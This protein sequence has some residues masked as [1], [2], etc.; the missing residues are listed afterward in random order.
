MA[1]VV[2]DRVQ[3]TSSTTGTGT[4][5]LSGAVN[6]F[7]T[8]SSVL[9]NGD[10]TYYC[11]TDSVNNDFEVGLGTYSAGTLARTTI[12]ESTNA[13]SAVNFGAGVK[14]VFITYP[15]EKAVY[16]DASDNITVPG[17]VD[18]RDIASDG[19]KLDGIEAG[20]DVTDT[21][22]V[23]AAGALMD[24]E[25]TSLSGVKTLTVPDNT[26]ISTFGATLV[27]DADAATSRTTLGLG[28]ASTQDVGTSA[29]NVVQLD[30]SARLPA[31]DGSQL[32]GIVSIPSGVITMWSGTV[33]SIPSGW[34]ICDGLNGTPNLTGR[35]VI[36]ADADAAG[37]YNVG[38]TGGSSTVALSEAEMP[39]HTHTVS[40]NTSNTGA[41]THTGNT[42]NTGAH[43][44]TGNTSNSGNHTHTG[45][46]SNTGAHSHSGTTANVGNHTHNG[47][48]SNTGAHS[49]N[50]SVP[51]N[52]LYGVG[53]N[54]FGG[55]AS[56]TAFNV[57]ISTS[58]TGAHSHNFTTAGGGSHAHNFNTS[59][60]GAHS[61]SFTTA[62]GGD[63]SHSYTT[64]SSGAHSHTLTVDSGGAHSHT[65]SGTAAASGSGT[66]HENRPPYY[67]LAYI[68][69]T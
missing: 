55:S 23:T 58:N 34:V 16:L 44:H 18:G 59:N 28:T 52:Q 68:M 49:H 63:H 36:H 21:A 43:T 13:G 56:G 69:K 9:S 38:D 41:H 14:E 29:G 67:A 31:V 17:L 25:L 6:G 45:N 54:R 37:T 33:A 57:G 1:F 47:S 35:F 50:A 53:T 20:A 19:S 40:G 5:T 60:T 48:T 27:D 4:F 39:S 3:E 12:I 8:F 66:A 11:I 7:R 15:A 65:I 30:G 64:D 2:R 51:G 26:T 10:T 61:H 32:T 42:S 62:G 22:N 24:S 46:T